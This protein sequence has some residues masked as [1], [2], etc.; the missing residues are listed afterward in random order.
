MLTWVEREYQIAMKSRD[1]IGN[2][3]SAVES[4]AMRNEKASIK[5]I[6]SGEV[7][8]GATVQG[9]DSPRNVIEAEQVP[10]NPPLLKRLDNKN[11]IGD[12]GV[13]TLPSKL[14]N[15]GFPKI[16]RN[17]LT[18][19]K[20]SYSSGLV[21]SAN[22]RRT[23]AGLLPQEV[24]PATKSSSL[25]RQ[26]DG[27]RLPSVVSLGN[28]PHDPTT[29]MKS[30]PGMYSRVNSAKNITEALNNKHSPSVS[31]LPDGSKSVIRNPPSLFGSSPV[32][33]GKGAQQPLLSSQYGSSPPQHSTPHGKPIT[34]NQHQLHRELSAVKSETL[35]TH[36]YNDSNN[37][38][39]RK[40]DTKSP[41]STTIYESSE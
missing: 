34:S 24:T 35:L 15:S 6:A 31:R 2:L 17:L 4:P 12:I 41:M 23:S 22:K 3:P 8:L 20:R 1:V 33:I 5:S 39:Q 26:I 40:Q 18:S 19:D 7:A 36:H 37:F 38:E 9:N 14:A 16:T 21:E 28:S 30:L 29:K 25:S 32:V 10:K 27:V 13:D 11:S